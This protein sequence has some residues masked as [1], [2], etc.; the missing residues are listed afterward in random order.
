MSLKQLQDYKHQLQKG[1]FVVGAVIFLV[2]GYCL[3][4]H[5]LPFILF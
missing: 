1:R 4:A 3:F 2:G 5:Q